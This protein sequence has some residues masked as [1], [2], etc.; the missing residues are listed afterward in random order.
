M[1]GRRLRPLPGLVACGLAAI[2]AAPLAAVEGAWVDDG[3]AK[4]RLISGRARVRPPADPELGLEFALAPGWHVYWKNPG[5]AGYPPGLRF[6]PGGPI[7]EAVLRYPAPRRFDLP[8]GL[9]AI[10]YDEDVV[11]PIDAR[12]APELTLPGAG[13][14]P[15]VAAT[16]DYLVCA[17]SCVPHRTELELPLPAGDPAEDSATAARLAD[18]RGRLPRSLDAAGAPAV[19]A[20]L[21]SGPGSG[22]TL[23]F[24]LRT[25]RQPATAPDLFFDSDPTLEIGR[26]Q[27]VASGEGPGFRVP[28]RPADETRPLPDRVRL[29]WTVTGWSL[30]GRPAAYAGRLDLAP[31]APAATPTAELVDAA[32]LVLVTIF[33]VLAIRRFRRRPFA[34]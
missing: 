18:W 11:Y 27:P 29:S 21:E 17:E 8:G 1:H 13:P 19:D 28:L 31:P 9:E 7:G 30:D 34:S 26:P 23:L 5:D 10:G 24:T 15:T 6:A 33:F 32:V 12:W 4:V 22:M 25:T 2:L 14:G 20:R 16:V 3:Q